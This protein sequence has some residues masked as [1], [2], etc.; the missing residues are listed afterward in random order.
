MVYIVRDRN[1]FLICLINW[2]QFITPGSVFGANGR[3]YI[4]TSLCVPED[5]ILEAR[6]RIRSKF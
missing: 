2:V 3:N 1:W 6:E 5:K 4:R